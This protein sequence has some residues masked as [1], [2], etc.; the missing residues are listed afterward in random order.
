MLFLRKYLLLIFLIANLTAEYVMLIPISKVLFYSVL[1]ISVPTCLAEIN[2][3]NKLKVWNKYLILMCCIYILYQ[4][5]VG[6]VYSTVDNW[7][8]LIA[9]CTTFIVM[10]M[11]INSNFDF[12]FRKIIQPLGYIIVV[13]LLVGYV[14]QP[15]DESGQYR[16]G[17]TN[18]NAACTIA[19]IGFATFFFREKYQWKDKLMI[20]F[21]VICV[22]LGGS[23]NA[24]AMI[25]LLICIRF[26]FSFK[27]LFILISGFVI[28]LVILPQIGF[29]ITALERLIGTFTG[30][31]KVD[32]EA[33]REAAIWMISQN[34]WQGN[35]FKFTNYGYA[36][37]L[38]RYG[39]HNG[40]LEILEMMGVFMGGLW[41]IVLGC[42]IFSLLSLYKIRSLDVKFHLGVVWV[43]L[44]AANQ[45]SFLTGVNQII[46]NLFFVSFVVLCLYKHYISNNNIIKTMSI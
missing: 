32:R 46:T 35:G 22:L 26:G 2:R 13:L 12:Y 24:L 29:Q 6:W 23:R 14:L 40:Y 10:M 21:C 11:S 4:C 8:Y 39:A 33:E 1:A 25:L 18:R 37:S 38:T 5:T 16:F 43:I 17:F 31:V 20:S 27:L 30:E 3:S 42:G 28:V 45:E 41:L 36:L 34:P 15:V 7:L 19:V 9:K 44:F